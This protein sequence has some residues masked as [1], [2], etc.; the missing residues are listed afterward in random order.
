MDAHQRLVGDG[1]KHSLN[2]R[3]NVGGR[4][5]S[6]PPGSASGLS[7]RP[8][9]S[10]RRSGRAPYEEQ[11]KQWMHGACSL[12]APTTKRHRAANTPGGCRPTTTACSYT[13]PRGQEASRRRQVHPAEPGRGAAPSVAR[14]RAAA[15]GSGAI[16]PIHPLTPI[17]RVRP[18][19]HRV[20][21][22]GGVLAGVVIAAVNDLMLMGEGV[23]LLP[24]G[25]SELYL[26]LGISV[27][28]GATWFFGLFDR[29]NHHLRVR[30]G[31]CHVPSG[32][33]CSCHDEGSLHGAGVDLAVERI[34]ARLE[35]RNL[36]RRGLRSLEDVTPEQHVLRLVALEDRQVV[37]QRSPCCRG[38]W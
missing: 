12:R 11:G 35:R 23:T 3:Q 29:G 2:L 37:G 7:P 15:D 20:A 26:L 4:D 1:G 28:S 18:R 6:V 27:G 16:P 13:S 33:P 19:W 5:Q 14:G 9:H 36:V 30:T 22:W 25:H 21:G 38:R 34:S 10:R 8:I 31:G 32:L 17:Y 24:G